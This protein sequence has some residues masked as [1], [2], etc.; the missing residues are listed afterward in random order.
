[1]P[2][3]SAKQHRFMAAIAH[4]PSFAKKVGV[5]QSVG[6]DFTAADKGKTF[7]Q[8]GIMKKSKFFTGGEMEGFTPDESYDEEGNPS[9]VYRKSFGSG[10][11][12]KKDQSKPVRRIVSRAEAKAIEDETKRNEALIASDKESAIKRGKDSIGEGARKFR[13]DFAKQ[14]AQE[15]NLRQAARAKQT[16]QKGGGVKNLK[17]L[18]KGKES[19]GEELKEAKAIKSGKISPQ[20][21]AKG[22][23]MEKAKYAKGGGIESRG[24]T[25][26]TMVRMAMGGSVGSASRRA[27]G[28]AQRGKTKC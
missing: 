1:M 3:T 6:K 5:S 20:Q 8:G 15:T 4:S 19:Y 11:S 2:S 21:Y 26:G 28:I 7:K 27:D 23:G 18:F 17:S 24:K 10:V 9:T 22:E 14:T 25:K 13:S 12:M 16:Y